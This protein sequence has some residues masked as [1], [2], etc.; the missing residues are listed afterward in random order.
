MRNMGVGQSGIERL[1]DTVSSR[2]ETVFLRKENE[3]A[4]NVGDVLK[5]QSCP[6]LLVAIGRSASNG[7]A[8]G[9]TTDERTDRHFEW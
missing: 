4:I 7:I 2:L 3:G 9:V 8:R 1:S 5:L 6:R